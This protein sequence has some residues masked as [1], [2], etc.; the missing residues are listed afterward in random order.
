MHGA[1]SYI[2]LLYKWR[3]YSIYWACLISKP[4]CQGRIAR[5]LIYQDCQI[6]NCVSTTVRAQY[7]WYVFTIQV[8]I[9][10]NVYIWSFVNGIDQFCMKKDI[11][12]K[13]QE[14]YNI[15]RSIWSVFLFSMLWTTTSW[16]GSAWRRLQLMSWR[17]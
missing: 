9:A 14:K 4:N 10:E 11:S 13:A 17:W 16:S 6:A 5:Q 8:Q 15:L 2:K 7:R 12:D 3:H 1:W